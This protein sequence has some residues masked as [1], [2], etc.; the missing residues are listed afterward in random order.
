MARMPGW[1]VAADLQTPSVRTVHVPYTE[2]Y[3]YTLVID[4][5][6]ISERRTLSYTP[7]ISIFHSATT[8]GIDHGTLEAG[9]SGLD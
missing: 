8:K 7:I 4:G 6:L 9:E 2:G 1:S 3:N 5:F